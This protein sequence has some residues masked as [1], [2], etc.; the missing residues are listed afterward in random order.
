MMMMLLLAGPTAVGDIS[1]ADL[2]QLR[3]VVSCWQLFGAR[4]SSLAA[5]DTRGHS[6]HE[7]DQQGDPEA[8]P[9]PDGEGGVGVV[10]VAGVGI[11]RYRWDDQG[12]L[13]VR[14][15]SGIGGWR[16]RVRRWCRHGDAC[17]AGFGRRRWGRYG[18]GDGGSSGAGKGLVADRTGRRRG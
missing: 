2:R 6:H 18:R 8:E 17:C 7:K 4:A 16:C 15:A 9:E 5:V 14:T 12:C 1:L 10:C 11:A 3:D 13:V